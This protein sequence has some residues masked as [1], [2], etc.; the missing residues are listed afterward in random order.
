M[1]N[2]IIDQPGNLALAYGGSVPGLDVR[3][4]LSSDVTTL[5]ETIG[6][7]AGAA[8]FVDAAHGDYHLQMGSLGI[9]YAPAIAADARDLDNLPRDQDLPGTNVWGSRDLGA[10]ERQRTLACT[11]GDTIFCDGFD[12]D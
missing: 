2:T 12:N 10:Y 3:Y 4:V 11:I 7:L 1:V 8:T 6:V 9:D 5:P